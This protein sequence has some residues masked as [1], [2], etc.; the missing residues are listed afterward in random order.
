MEISAAAV[1]TKPMSTQKKHV[2][3]TLTTTKTFGT[4]QTAYALLTPEVSDNFHKLS[5]RNSGQLDA[6][7]LRL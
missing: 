7:Y 5:I 4:P 6:A 1:G 3:M 2:H